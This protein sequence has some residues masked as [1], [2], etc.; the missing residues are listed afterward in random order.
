MSGQLI[1]DLPTTKNF[2]SKD[3]FVSKS[4][5]DAVKLINLFPNWHNNGIVIYGPKKS[6]KSHLAHIWKTTANANLYNFENDLDI[7]SIDTFNN[8]IFDNF[9]SLSSDYEKSIFQIYNDIINNKKFILILI[10]KNEFS[11]KLDDLR[12]RI[13]ALNSAKITDPDDPLIH[14]IILKFFYD[15]CYINF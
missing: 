8:C 14:A 2:N 9:N 4:N 6:G 10:E 15:E 12:S 13:A 5:S 3:F 1:F 11:I 7:H